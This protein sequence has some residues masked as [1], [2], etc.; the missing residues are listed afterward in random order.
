MLRLAAE[1]ALLATFRREGARTIESY[2]VSRMADAYEEAYAAAQFV[3]KRQNRSR[4]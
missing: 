3:S 1:P 4:H 2:T